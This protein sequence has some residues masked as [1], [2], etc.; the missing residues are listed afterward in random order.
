ML[1]PPPA[2]GRLVSLGYYFILLTV[3]TNRGAKKTISTAKYRVTSRGGR[4]N[5]IQK[6]GQISEI[7]ADP[8]EAPAELPN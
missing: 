1:R 3:K 5:E 2:A 4:G 7:V 6:N 8:I